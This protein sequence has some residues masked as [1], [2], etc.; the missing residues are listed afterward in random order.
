[1]S[2]DAHQYLNKL[3][4]GNDAD[5]QKSYADFEETFQLPDYVWKKDKKKAE[6]A[7]RAKAEAE[8]APAKA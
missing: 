4:K 2:R 7:A 1:M 5:Y 3:K 6:A 8:A